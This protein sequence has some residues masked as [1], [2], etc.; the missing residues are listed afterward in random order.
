MTLSDAIA[1]ALW[2]SAHHGLR[3]WRHLPGDTAPYPR[4]ARRALLWSHVYDLTAMLGHPAAPGGP[5]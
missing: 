1:A 2:V 5:R 4:L 3:A